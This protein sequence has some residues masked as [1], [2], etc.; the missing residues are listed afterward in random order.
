MTVQKAKAICA[1]TGCVVYGTYVELGGTPMILQDNNGTPQFI[2]VDRATVKASLGVKDA[3]GAELFEGDF[4]E[5]TE[6]HTVY[7]LQYNSNY[8]FSLVHPFAFLSTGT[9]RIRKVRA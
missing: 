6:T 9:A 7:A 5:N 3:S 8:P 4:V 2:P 1:G